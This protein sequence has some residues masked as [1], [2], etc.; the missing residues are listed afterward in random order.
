MDLWRRDVDNA[1]RPHEALG[2]LAPATRWRPCERQRPSQ[3]PT[4][5]Y[6]EN[7]VVRKVSTVGDVRWRGAKLLA[8]NGL[9]G[10]FVRI[11]EIDNL[12]NLWYGA[13]RIRQIPL[14]QLRTSGIL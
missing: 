5:E 12:V 6:P 10:E 13:H 11:E 4:V 7:A 9:V 14:D 2:D 8:G 1:I 3:L